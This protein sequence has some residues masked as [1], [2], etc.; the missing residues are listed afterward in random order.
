MNFRGVTVGL[1]S[2]DNTDRLDC[3]DFCIQTVIICSS[4]T[5]PLGC[6]ILLVSR[7]SEK[8]CN[9]LWNAQRREAHLKEEHY[10]TLPEVTWSQ[11]LAWM[12]TCGGICWNF[13]QHRRNSDSCVNHRLNT[14]SFES[15]V[16]FLSWNLPFIN[17]GI[18]HILERGCAADIV[19]FWA[20]VKKDI[21]YIK[22][23]QF[24]TDMTM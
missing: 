3:F 14:N 21:F 7:Y 11:R 16:K 2:S 8:N 19:N 10:W 15:R 5:P 4:S 23:N 24:C 9:F 22:R 17:M 20:W 13:L 1:S 12:V 18:I 6:N